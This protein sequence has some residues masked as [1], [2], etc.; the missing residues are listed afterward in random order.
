MIPS[1]AEPRHEVLEKTIGPAL[2]DMRASMT[3]AKTGATAKQIEQR[4]HRAE[5]GEEP[6]ARTS[7]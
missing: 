5:K 6:A 2:E 3:G 1:K 7:N 4:I